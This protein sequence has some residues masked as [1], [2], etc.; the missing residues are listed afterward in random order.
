[1]LAPL[2]I[3]YLFHNS[4]NAPKMLIYYLCQHALTRLA[5]HLFTSDTPS[6]HAAISQR[7]AF[8]KFSWVFLYTPHWSSPVALADFLQDSLQSNLHYQFICDN[9]RSDYR[10]HIQL[11]LFCFQGG[12]EYQL[13]FMASSWAKSSASHKHQTSWQPSTTLDARCIRLKTRKMKNLETI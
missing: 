4:I 11:Y 2:H 9:T 10:K 1:M 6:L 5:R 13:C 3:L 12:D 8:R 7:S